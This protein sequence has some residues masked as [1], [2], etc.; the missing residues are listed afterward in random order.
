MEILKIKQNEDMRFK[1]QKGRKI[2]NI[3]RL[4][5][6]DYKRKK[7]GVVD[8]IV[9]EELSS[10]KYRIHGKVDEILFL[11]DGTSSPLDYK[12]AEYKGKIFKTYKFQ[13]ILY[14]LLIEENYNKIVSKGYI[15]YTR[16]K[17]KILELEFKAADIDKVKKMID[18]IQK[19]LENNHFPRATNTK[20]RCLDCCYRNI[21]VK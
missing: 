20:K 5:N 18:N 2:H 11:N 21:C 19:I 1:V 13:S 8:K 4:T 6:A 14:G 15:V 10:E 16:S 17:N 7:L 9:E 3:K 12:F